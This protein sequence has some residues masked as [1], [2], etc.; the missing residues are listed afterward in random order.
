MLQRFDD[1][2]L[3]PNRFSDIVL[4]SLSKCMQSPSPQLS[5]ASTPRRVTVIR[6]ASWV[7]LVALLM[8]WATMHLVAERW[9]WGT[10]LLYG[11]RWLWALPLPLLALA[12]LCKRRRSLW[13]LAI[14]GLILIGPVMDLCIPWRKLS[15]P[16]PSRLS[17]RV[18]TCN[19]HGPA[20]DVHAMAKL[21]AETRPDIFAIQESYRQ[22]AAEV[23]GKKGWYIAG[24]GEIWLGSRY[25]LKIVRIFPSREGTGDHSVA[26]KFVLTTPAGELTFYDLHL[27]SP[28]DVF[29]DTLLRKPG[30]ERPLFSNIKL[31]LRQATAIADDARRVDGAVMLAGDFNLPSDSA[32]Y[33]QTFSLFT[34]A[35]ST[36]GFGFGWTY[37]VHW[38][39]TR[40]DHILC[41]HDF[42]CRRCWVGGNVGSPHRPLIADFTWNA[43]P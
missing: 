13:I 27:I 18:L 17:L 40:I 20:M 19:A 25:P 9:W 10:M 28:H 11:P 42:T 31:R 1:L 37:R 23:L 12:A 43:R 29:R 41:N 26:V 22:V 39:T 24:E 33:G 35:F 38:T 16:P 7:Y 6:W 4:P 3:Y 21:V 34:D 15:T 30:A 2:M 14:A 32:A 5:P 8:G 36:V